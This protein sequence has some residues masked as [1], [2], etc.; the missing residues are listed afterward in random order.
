MAAIAVTIK[1]T[2]LSKSPKGGE[3]SPSGRQDVVICGLLHL[4][5]LYV[6]ADPPVVVLPPDPVPPGTPIFPIW[7]PPGS[8]F[9]PIGGYP[10]VAGHPLPQPPDPAPNP[11]DDGL[12]KPPPA[13]GGWGYH[14][15]YGW[16][17]FPGPG[18]AG[19][20]RRA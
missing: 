4:T 15:D 3:V 19:P 10:P 13:D 11:P 12:A 8:E 1:G 16:G 17:Y 2:M 7:G 14:P 9:P 20:K 6:D 18:E 5:G